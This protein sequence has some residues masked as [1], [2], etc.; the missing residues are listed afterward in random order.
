MIEITTNP[1]D[2]DR[3]LQEVSNPGCGASVLFL[4]TTRGVTAGQ[5]TVRLTYEC[6]E[7]MARRVL[8][9]LES[10][11]RQRWPI[12]G[13]AIVHR[14]GDVGVAEASVAVAVSTPHRADAFA[15]GQWLIDEIKVR[16]PIWKKE[17][18]VNGQE[19]WQH[20]GEAREKSRTSVAP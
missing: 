19:I 14:V 3:L 4:G 1:I 11:A 9:E 17:I 8:A 12:Q 10:E 2:T 6:Y 16:A 18:G 5:I 7:P 20:P 13:C 15:A